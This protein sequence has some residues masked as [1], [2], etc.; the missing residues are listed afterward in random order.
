MSKRKREFVGRVVCGFVNRRMNGIGKR[1]IEE[2]SAVVNGKVKARA[3]HAHIELAPGVVVFKGA[4]SVENVDV[5]ELAPLG[6]V[7]GG[8][9][10]ARS[11]ALERVLQYRFAQ[12]F[13]K[14]GKVEKP[15]AGKMAVKDSMRRRTL[16][17][18]MLAP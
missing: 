14:V 4:R 8:N 13:L 12:E 18:Q 7:Y 9:N 2:R 5:I 11:R 3:G 16:S 6:F 10:D 17:I 1:L 15:S